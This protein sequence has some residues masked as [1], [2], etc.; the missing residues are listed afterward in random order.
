MLEQTK[1]Y[2]TVKMK[3]FLVLINAN[4]WGGPG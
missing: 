3:V 2:E 4:I 1:L